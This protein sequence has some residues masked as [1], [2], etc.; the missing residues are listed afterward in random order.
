MGEKQAVGRRCLPQD[1]VAAH[2]TAK[3]DYLG[4]PKQV[5]N[6]YQEH[7]EENPPIFV[8]G[9]YEATVCMELASVSM[10]VG[11]NI[12]MYCPEHLAHGNSEYYASGDDSF[13]VPKQTDLTMSYTII[14]CQDDVNVLN[15]NVK[16]FHDNIINKRKAL[17]AAEKAKLQAEADAKAKGIAA[18]EAEND[19]ADVKAEAKKMEGK[20]KVKTE[21]EKADET[22]KEDES[23]KTAEDEEKLNKDKAEV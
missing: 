15:K 23:P 11:E 4:H 8:L 5:Q 12:K 9:K 16:V 7:G 17:I 19:A 1:F 2:W 13:V 10:H 3:M 6:T 14:D 21:D 22:V 20:K 18:K